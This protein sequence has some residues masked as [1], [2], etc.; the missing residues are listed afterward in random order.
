[1]SA[2]ANGNN[3][4]TVAAQ[5]G[6]TDHVALLVVNFGATTAPLS[7]S[8]RGPL[9]MAARNGHTATVEFLLEA[10]RKATGSA[11]PPTARELLSA[12][13]AAR[14]HGHN[15]LA[16]LLVGCVPARKQTRVEPRGAGTAT[17]LPPLPLG[18]A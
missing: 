16:R 5:Q 10:G 18:E 2:A 8:R 6:L 15:A 13:K 1:M 11:V 17:R 3:A 4:V 14:A 12:A 9:L 7:P